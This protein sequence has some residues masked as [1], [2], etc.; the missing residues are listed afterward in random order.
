MGSMAHFVL[1]QAPAS[2]SSGASS[3]HAGGGRSCLRNVLMVP[4]PSNLDE[5]RDRLGVRVHTWYGLTEAG[6]PVASVDWVVHGAS[7]GRARPGFQ[8]IVVDDRD[9]PVAPGVPGELLLRSDV[10]W[11][12]TRGYWNKPEATVE[13]WR[14][15]W[16][17]TGDRVRMG[18]DGQIY[19]LDRMKDA[20][21]RRGENI[22][23][24]EVEREVDAHPAVAESAAF[25]VPAQWGEDEV[26]V[27]VVR[28][29][30]CALEP[31]ELHDFLLA[32]LPHFMIPRYIEFVAELPRT[33]T[34]KVQKSVLRQRGVSTE[35]WDREA[36]GIQ[37]RRS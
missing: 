23:S 15:L 36:W 19:F 2:A 30:G 13:L 26:M 1:S 6:A 12:M 11:T 34:A 8:A 33:P 5:F 21:R 29:P 10:A 16:L 35:T 9:E 7:C 22:S 14:N 31:V 3:E 28:Q 27:A 17:H 32:R 25:A 4:V 20:I 24:L 37:V 18:A